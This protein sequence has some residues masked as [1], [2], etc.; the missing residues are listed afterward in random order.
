VPGNVFVILCFGRLVRDKGIDTLIQAVNLLPDSVLGRLCVLIG[1]EGAEL[2]NLRRMAAPQAKHAVRFLGPV[3]QTSTCYSAADLFVLPSRHEPFGLVFLEAAAHGLPSIGTR[4]GG[5][6]EIV[7]DG[8]TGLLVKPADP[9]ALADAIVRL[10][11]D[12]ELRLRLGEAARARVGELFTADSMVKGYATLFRNLLS[13][14]KGD[15]APAAQA[16]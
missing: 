8:V 14:S 10:S 9:G 11:T 12:D 3:G 13:A 4:V 5:I 2:E 6:P 1:G 7:L 16:S 15:I